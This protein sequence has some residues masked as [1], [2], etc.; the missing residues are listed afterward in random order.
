MADNNAQANDIDIRF[1]VL[2]QFVDAARENLDDGAWDY[3]IGGAETETT[4]KRNR[5]A[6]DRLAFRPRVMRDVN[7]LSAGTSFLGR[8]LR[9]PIIL[10]P[11]GSLQQFFE[12]GGSGVSK[13]AG[14]FGV[15]HML[16]SVCKP[17]LEAVAEAAPDAHRIFQLYVRGDAVRAPV[18]KPNAPPPPEVEKFTPSVTLLLLDIAPLFAD[19]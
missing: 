6:L 17:G 4:Q 14:T 13:A 8:D 11:I 7:G 2:H 3:L 16:S 18:G 9:L 10:A 15:M 1:Q 12:E 19:D 5:L